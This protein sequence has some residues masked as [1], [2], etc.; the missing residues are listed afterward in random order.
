MTREEIIERLK[1]GDKFSG[2][3]GAFDGIMTPSKVNELTD[4]LVVVCHK[5]GCQWIENWDD[6]QCTIWAFERGEYY[7][8]D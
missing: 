6:L 3:Y 4:S 5:D 7:F 2:R 1:L 8:I